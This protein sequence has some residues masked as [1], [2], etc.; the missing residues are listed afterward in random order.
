MCRKVHYII[1]LSRP[2]SLALNASHT[3]TTMTFTLSPA[4]PADV[5]GILDV[6]FAANGESE[7]VQSY[8]NSPEVC[9]YLTECYTLSIE[10]DQD[11][12]VVM[13]EETKVG[14]R[15]VGAFAKVSLEKGGQPPSDYKARWRAK[16]PEVAS[17]ESVEAIMA[18]IARQRAVIMGE[19][20]HRCKSLF[21]HLRESS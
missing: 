7:R 4:T 1:I 19:R 21:S 9:K 2:Y 6:W 12:V 3:A 15:R 14:K 11:V 18:P 20:A 13:T 5:P 10:E 16:L 17:T 8:K